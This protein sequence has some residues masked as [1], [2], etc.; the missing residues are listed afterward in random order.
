MM[1]VWVTISVKDSK[2]SGRSYRSPAK[3]HST[4][5]L[6]YNGTTTI[7]SFW[8]C[9]MAG[10]PGI[11]KASLEILTPFV[12]SYPC[13]QGFS[14]LVEIKTKKRS[15]LNCEQDMIVA[16]SKTEP[17]ISHIVYKNQQQRKH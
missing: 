13:E 2:L 10:Y 5:G 7:S 11:A 6:W 3:P 12:T 9:Q 8:C 17:S 4:S 14:K 1:S 15:R 16:L